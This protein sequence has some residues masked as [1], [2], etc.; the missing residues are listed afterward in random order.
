LAQAMRLL[1]GPQ[2]RA[3]LLHDGLG[4]T[5]TETAQE[6]EV[7]EGTVKSWLSRSRTIVAAELNRPPRGP[8]TEVVNHDI[9]N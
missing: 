5:V 1:P 6:L 8:R 4:L 9:A 7:P 3:L 2:A